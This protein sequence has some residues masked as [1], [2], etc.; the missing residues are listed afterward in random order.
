VVTQT[1]SDRSERAAA[2]TRLFGVAL[3]ATLLVTGGLDLPWRLSGLGFGALVIWSGAR[4][5]G[6]LGALR[7]AGTPAP[8]R[9]GVIVGLGLT[10]LMMLVLLGELVLYPLVADQERC[11]GGAITHQD[12]AQCRLDYERRQRELMHRFQAASA[13]S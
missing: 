4:L 1:V 12:Q 5:L 2:H 7:R 8:S 13:D 11:L 10:A 3:L 6:D 9:G